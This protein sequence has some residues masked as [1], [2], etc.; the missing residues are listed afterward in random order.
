MSE[1]TEKTTIA[2]RLRDGSRL[3]NTLDPF[4]F[5]EG[6]LDPDADAYIVEWA[7]ELP[8]NEPIT[9]VIHL[10]EPDPAEK[11]APDL[12]TAI[13]TWFSNKAR[14]ETRALREL[15]R[16]GR[17]AFAIGLVAL[18]ICLFLSWLLTQSREGPFVR[19]FQESFI[20]IGWVV[21][22]R[23]AEMFLY[24]WLPIM[25]R[26]RLYRRLAQARVEVRTAAPR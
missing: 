3:F 21:I 6:D 1:P 12:A 15:F 20:I 9:I 11:P 8:K 23:P 4:P 7:G 19:I 22:W 5:R 16:D 10:Q 17:L 24:D 14:A 18:A 13:A 2:L 26:R 25:R